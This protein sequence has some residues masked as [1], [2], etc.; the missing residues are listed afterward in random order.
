[1]R[2]RATLERARAAIRA[3]RERA[4]RSRAALG[5]AERLADESQR[6]MDA[7]AALRDQLRAAVTAYVRD[8]RDDGLP[9]ERVVVLVKSAIREATPP[10]LDPSEARQLMADA[11]RWTVE[12]YYEAA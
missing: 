6:I 10:E 3:S 7:S 5:R 8:L 1:M 12:A 9:S 2:V 11:V 4:L